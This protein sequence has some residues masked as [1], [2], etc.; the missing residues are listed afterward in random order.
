MFKSC[1]L[2][3]NQFLSTTWS[4]WN[5]Q[6]ILHC[7]KNLGNFLTKELGNVSLNIKEE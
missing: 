4:Q 2:T 7:P 1:L 5:L 3:D 6:T